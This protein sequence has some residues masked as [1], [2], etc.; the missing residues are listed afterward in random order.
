MPLSSDQNL[1]GRY[2]KREDFDAV[3]C[4]MSRN[5]ERSERSITAP[6]TGKILHCG[7]GM[8]IVGTGEGVLQVS[9]VETTLLQPFINHPNNWSNLGHH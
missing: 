5:I 4:V 2:C 8:F 6:P 7:A 9:C 3:G 1:L